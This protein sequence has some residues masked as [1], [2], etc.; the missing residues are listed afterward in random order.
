[1]RACLRLLPVVVALFAAHSV[2]AELVCS[3]VP[4]LQARFLQHH[5][6]YRAAE[7][8]LWERTAKTYLERLDSQ[9]ILYL[10]P[11]A[12]KVRLSLVQAAKE[13][14]N[15]DCGRLRQVHADLLVRT[16]RMEAEVRGYVLSPSYELDPSAE[17][18]LDPAERGWPAN[19]EARVHALHALVHFQI[20]NIE[21][22]SETREEARKRVVHRYELRSKRTQET[23]PDDL[24]STWLDAFANALDPHSNYFSGDAFED[25]QIQMQLS[26]E[27]IGVA[28]QDREG[29]AVV[30][31]VLPGSAAAR[32]G[33]LAVGDKIVEVEKDG[34]FVDIADM[35][36]DDIVRMI[37]GPKGTQVRLTVI[38]DEPPKR[39]QLALTR[40][41]ID[42]EEQAAK[43]RMEPLTVDGRTLKLAV[44]TLP[45]FYGS[46]DPRERLASRDVRRLLE[47]ARRERAD[48]LLLD[49]AV[50]GGG[51]LEDAVRIA[52]FFLHDGGIV[53]V[54]EGYR[55]HVLRDPE[56][57]IG[58]VGPM[59]V[60]TSRVSASASEI[61]AGALKDYRRAVVVGD[62]ATFG[63]GTVQS[64]IDQ[65]PGRGAIKVTTGMFFRPG[66]ASTQNEG[67]R[68]DVVLPSLLTPD[69]VGESTE[70]N[71]LPSERVAPFVADTAN[72]AKGLGRWQPVTDKV[73]AELIRRSALRVSRDPM[74]DQIR[75][76]LA[77]RQADKGK[78]KLSA[79]IA[80]REA[81]EKKDSDA[82]KPEGAA[83]A[84]SG[85]A[86]ATPS[87]G[88]AATTG[89]A[90][91]VRPSGAPDDLG[92]EKADEPRPDLDEALRVLGDLIV[93]ETAQ[94]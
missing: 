22:G 57:G 24:L 66:G 2:R 75:T 4:D 68:A 35:A 72:A 33:T 20:S 82:A 18:T 63:K 50:N 70:E 12:E 84:K 45:G 62:E 86:A 42:L 74:F 48:G 46:G 65:N 93:L 92:A 1:M 55:S 31:Q 14:K 43:L 8:M 67:V 3:D 28:L 11:E 54:R 80:R 56:G 39:F 64:M 69:L 53:A 10:A 90:A 78:V 83:K 6:R 17:L 47:Q 52:G 73:V 88:G 60:L 58:W 79:L 37:R 44:L 59:V 9:R 26:L 87:A 23:S 34:E 38:R 85:T 41:K 29:S 15:G 19:E 91:A 30:Q 49:L 51:L 76:D 13:I 5:I 89:L 71:A 21:T 16:K 40:D 32:D 25:F 94:S 27:G 36:L 7:P 77:E 61:V 81:E